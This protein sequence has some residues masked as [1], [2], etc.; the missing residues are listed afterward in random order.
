MKLYPNVPSLGVPYGRAG[1]ET[2]P[3]LGLQW[4]RVASI[5]GD[6]SMIGPARQ[7]AQ[8]FSTASVVYKY[9]FNAT[10]PLAGFPDSAGAAHGDEVN[11][12]WALP[13]L[14][15]GTAQ[16]QLVDLMSRAWVSFVV[17]LDPNNHGLKGIPRWE[18]YTSRVHGAGFVFQL[19]NLTMETDDYRHDGIELLNRIKLSTSQ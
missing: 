17:D 12:V 1:N 16:T 4:R 3:A 13:G 8:I 18:D 6:Q 9:R 14:R 2:F 11:F 5:A 19:D 15:N 7:T 10:N